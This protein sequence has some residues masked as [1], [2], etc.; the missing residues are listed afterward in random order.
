[1]RMENSPS[2]T[3]SELIYPG[4]QSKSALDDSPTSSHILFE[5]FPGCLSPD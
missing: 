2:M 4:V 1:M 5:G 3:E